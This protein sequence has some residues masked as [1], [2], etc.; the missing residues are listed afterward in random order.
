MNAHD[1]LLHGEPAVL[2]YG[3]GEYAVL[4]PGKFVLCAVS[5]AR[6]PLDALRYW[7]PIAQEAYAGP[8]EALARW[9]EL[10]PGGGAG[11]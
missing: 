5:G 9:R 6:I 1:P 10:N 8:A 4:K 3:D 2:H 11:E 7:N